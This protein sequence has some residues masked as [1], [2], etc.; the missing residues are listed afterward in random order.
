MAKKNCLGSPPQVRGKPNRKR[1]NGRINRITPAGAG[2]TRSRINPDKAR[3]DHP[4]RC[5]ENRKSTAQNREHRGSP[6]QVRGKP[7]TKSNQRAPFGITP[8]GAGK[9]AHS[10]S[11]C[12]FVQ[13]HPRRCGEN[14]DSGRICCCYVGSPPQVRGKQFGDFRVQ[15]PS[16]ITPAGAG[17]TGLCGVSLFAPRDH[18]RRCGENCRRTG[19]KL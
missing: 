11:R 15:H 7:R 18:P 8:A 17:K 1:P 2:K 16:G 4:R 13:D 19:I 5:G 12:S 9:T 14:T 10:V 6:P 3:Q